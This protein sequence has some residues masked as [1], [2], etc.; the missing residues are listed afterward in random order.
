MFV[1]PDIDYDYTPSF[2]S[3]FY[4]KYTE[5]EHYNPIVSIITPIYNTGDI[6]LETIACVMGMPFL[7]WEWI[8]INDGSTN[9]RTLE[10]LST[11]EK[12]D[13][14]IKLFHQE[15]KGRSF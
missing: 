5:P 7:Q 13:K 11:L 10:L 12:N 15:N 2:P 4:K 6:F 1:A 14:R 8:I 9:P 3:R